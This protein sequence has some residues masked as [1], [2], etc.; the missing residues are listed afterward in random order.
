MLGEVATA[1]IRKK[2]LDDKTQP[3]AAYNPEGF[4]SIET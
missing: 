2:I 3:L 4:E 1:E